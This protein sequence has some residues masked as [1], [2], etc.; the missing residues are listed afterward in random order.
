MS[1]SPAPAPT[2]APSAAEKIERN[3]PSNLTL[4]RIRS[5]Q[6]LSEFKPLLS[7]AQKIAAVGALKE[8]CAD[9]SFRK[10]CAEICK[11]SGSHFKRSDL[12]NEL[13]KAIDILSSYLGRL[14]NGEFH[15]AS[16]H[17]SNIAVRQPYGRIIAFSAPNYPIGEN[18]AIIGVLN[19]VLAGCPV[20]LRLGASST[21]AID[22]YMATRVIQSLS[23]VLPAQFI[24]TMTVG[25]KDAKEKLSQYAGIF[26]IGG[27]AGLSLIE[28]TQ[29]KIGNLQTGRPNWMVVLEEDKLTRGKDILAKSVEGRFG[30]SC[31]GP[32]I[33]FVE[34]DADPM[35]KL[36]LQE[37]SRIK[38]KLAE[39]GDEVRADKR[40]ADS[41]DEAAKQYVKA[42]G[43]LVSGPD[44]YMTIVKISMQ[45]FVALSQ[46]N[47][48]VP[49][50]FGAGFVIV[51][52]AQIPRNNISP[53]NC[54]DLAN[55]PIAKTGI[56][57]GPQQDAIHIA[58]AT[59]DLVGRI[60]INM[61][62][63]TPSPGPSYRHKNV[64][65]HP[66]EQFHIICPEALL[67]PSKQV[68]IMPAGEAL[69][70]GWD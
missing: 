33:A 70:L 47:G 24:R 12:E 56:V 35:I 52:G 16:T 30:L 4:A 53:D 28:H 55:L 15:F 23:G 21:G 44:D 62:C 41:L 3:P 51:E 61:G 49:E 9:E 48:S 19:A 40:F 10:E 25:H 27:S 1:L 43:T 69:K 14:E 17:G 50:M 22:Q 39:N 45:D 64:D 38:S 65:G 46:A 60:A 8:L 54:G 7:Q 13:V 5:G 57:V 63:S 2:P 29:Y 34:G 37:G 66:A 18:A 68:Y 58:T 31:S 59:A 32:S 6:T 36:L 11:Q 20:D 42:G 26:F 67:Q